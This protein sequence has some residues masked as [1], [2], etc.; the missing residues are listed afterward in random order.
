VGRV[1]PFT[2]V[3][4]ITRSQRTILRNFT[5]LNGAGIDHQGLSNGGLIYKNI[6]LFNEAFYGVRRRRRRRDLDRRRAC[7]TAGTRRHADARKWL[8]DHQ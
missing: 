7:T 5:T 3:Q 4:T 2:T 1:W 6:I 8:R